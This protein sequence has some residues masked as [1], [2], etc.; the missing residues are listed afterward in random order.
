MR[1][2]RSCEGIAGQKRLKNGRGSDGGGGGIVHANGQPLSAT[3]VMISTTTTKDGF[4]GDVGR[5]QQRLGIAVE[6]DGGAGGGSG[7]G[8]QKE[9]PHTSQAATTAKD[10]MDDGA[11]QEAFAAR[12]RHRKSP[13]LAHEARNVGINEYMDTCMSI[14]PC[15]SI[16]FLGFARTDPSANSSSTGRQYPS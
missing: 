4:V 3:G 13:V 14:V 1:R 7:R 10:L 5:W 15:M 16:V 12:R 8:R 11:L 2:T 6:G 9:D